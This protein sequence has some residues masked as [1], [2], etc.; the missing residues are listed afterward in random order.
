MYHEDY[1]DG[2]IDGQRWQGYIEHKRLGDRRPHQGHGIALMIM[3]VQ[4]INKIIANT[5]Y[6][7]FVR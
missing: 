1:L 2:R 7:K 5:G 3:K 6:K 4:A